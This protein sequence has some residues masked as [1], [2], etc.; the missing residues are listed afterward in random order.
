[1][2]RI[3]GV[4]TFRNC[5]KTGYPFMEAILSALPICDE[6][7]V[8]DGGSDDGTLEYCLRLQTIFPDKVKVYD[9]QD[10][11]SDRWDCV[12]EQYN[13]LINESTGDW[14]FQGDADEV[15]HEDDLLKLKKHCEEEKEADVFRH[16][17]REV[18]Q[19]WALLGGGQP[20]P[21]L[22]AR[23]ARKVSGLRQQ[24]NS[25]GGDEFLDDTGWI[26]YPP[27]VRVLDDVMIWHL[28]VMFMGNV[29]AKR[30]NDALYVAQKDTHRVRIYE[31]TKEYKYNPRRI[32]ET[33]VLPNLPALVKGLVGM[34]EYEVREE[35]FDPKWLR[36]V[37]GL[38]Y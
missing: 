29:T 24:W 6:Y 2:V 1:M 21:Y 8:N 18:R 30:A 23:T 28:Y 22:P 33:K 11:P 13:Q 3:S 17:R 38:D 14:I 26:R 4:I 5:I 9:I 31:T 10:Y 27:R 16:H 12:S 7:L 15:I 32:D 20:I 36:E 25:H 35:L 19:D 34:H 37:T